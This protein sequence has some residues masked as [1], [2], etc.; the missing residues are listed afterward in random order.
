MLVQIKASGQRARARNTHA[1]RVCWVS[2]I[3]C[4]SASVAREPDL[5][6]VRDVTGFAD[7]IHSSQKQYALNVERSGIAGHSA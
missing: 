1:S 7:L 5:G 3:A 4:A 2:N 6:T